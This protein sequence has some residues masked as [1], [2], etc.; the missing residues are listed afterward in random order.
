MS[1]LPFKAS[2]LGFVIYVENT[3]GWDAVLSQKVPLFKARNVEAGILTKKM[4]TNPRLY[5]W[6]NLALAVE[7]LR[8]QRKPVKS[9]TAV[10][11]HVETAIKAA[12]QPA[13]VTTVQAEIDEALAWEYNHA[14]P[15]HVEWIG[16]LVRAGFGPGQRDVLVE[17]KAARA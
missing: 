12:N 14:L 7:Y 4:A 2:P 11:W 8:R 5:T 9:P 1:T 6:D 17:W 13:K 3:L 15:D 10:L 16:R